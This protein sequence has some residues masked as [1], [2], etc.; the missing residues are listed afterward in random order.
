MNPVF[1]MSLAA[2]CLVVTGCS[3]LQPGHG[4]DAVR[5]QVRRAGDVEIAWHAMED[6][7][8]GSPGSKVDFEKPL[9]RFDAVRFGLL[10][11]PRM[12]ALFEALGIADAERAAASVPG[13]PGVSI[14]AR[15]SDA[16]GTRTNLE[17]E[18]ATGLLD[19]LLLP[20]RRAMARTDFERVQLEVT[21]AVLAYT[22]EIQ[23]AWTAYVAAREHR[24]L[25]DASHHAGTA[26]RELAQRFEAAGNL[27]LLELAR[28]R[29]AE[30]ATA[31]QLADTRIAEYTARSELALLLGLE[32]AGD[33]QVPET[34]PEQ[35]PALPDL[36]ATVATGLSRRPDLAVHRKRIENTAAALRIARRYR[37]LGG[38]DFMLNGEREPDGSDLRGF[39]LA[40]ELP[41]FD[42]GQPEIARLQSLQRR[43]S[44][45]A[46]AIRAMARK[47]IA[48]AWHTARTLEDKL[49]TH[50]QLALPA[51]ADTVREAQLH[52]NYMLESIFHVLAARREQYA[53]RAGYVDTL[54][55]YWVARSQLELAIGGRT[56]MTAARDARGANGS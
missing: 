16:P 50:R 23:Q 13:N 42:Q 51:A 40:L 29:S 49:A 56:G 27:S 32:A 28:H 34:L 12:Q 5:E 22:G 21:D 43:Q 18:F 20:S 31:L 55:D 48:V 46:E 53:A 19:L 30:A 37:W 3:T 8:A 44:A 11:S 10:N 25:A 45:E 52:Q 7:D 35:G 26:A 4:F 39:G 9:T 14:L 1:R 47:Q 36:A 15:D 17:I 24:Q 38:A 33:W 6:S 41:V 54:H 2:A